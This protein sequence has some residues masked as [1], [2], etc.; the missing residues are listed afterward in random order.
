MSASM[1]K[2]AKN[3]QF[4][5]EYESFSREWT[6]AK[7]SGKTIDGKPMGKK[8]SFSMFKKRLKAYFAM[9]KVEHSLK[10]KQKM[11]QEKNIDLEWKDD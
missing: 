2:K 6:A 1:D 4:R 10:L 9:Q 3:N 8:P 11:D 7:L 5:V